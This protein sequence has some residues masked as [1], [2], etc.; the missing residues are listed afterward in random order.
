MTFQPTVVVQARVS[1]TRLPGKVMMP[2]LG[3]PLLWYLLERL[4][5]LK[6]VGVVVA[7]THHSSDDA[8]EALATA[9]GVA[10]HRG[11]MDDVLTRYHDAARAFDA[12]PV[13]RVTGDCPLID[14]EIVVAVLD[15][16][17]ETSAD[18]AANTLQRTFPRGLDV[19]VVAASAL[20]TAWREAKD[21]YEREHVT[22]FLYNRPS[23]FRL[24][25][26]ANTSDRSH[27]RW[28]VDT[29]EDFELVRTILEN[30]YP[31]QSHFRMNDVLR[32]LEEH[33]E[34]TLLNRSVQQRRVP[35]TYRPTPS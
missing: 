11:P 5:D 26:L 32:Y 15:L 30:L 7:T 9:L 2:V 12:D 13:I 1:S 31:K 14:P 23:R 8:I 25:N 33:P 16:Y 34:T 29:G 17:I 21:P 19:E 4:R 28:T 10:V 27:H 22:P 18:Y 3:R 24:R 6:K 35:S 20:E